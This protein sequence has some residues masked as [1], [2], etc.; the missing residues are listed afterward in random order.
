[1]RRRRPGHG[2]GDR[3][4]R[5]IPRRPQDGP[6]RPARAGP[7]ARRGQAAWPGGSMRTPVV[8]IAASVRNRANSRSA[9]SAPLGATHLD[10]GAQRRVLDADGPADVEQHVV[11][12]GQQRQPPDPGGLLRPAAQPVEPA[13]VGDEPFQWRPDRARRRTTSPRGGPARQP[14]QVHQQP[15]QHHGAE[16]DGQEDGDP[17]DDWVVPGHGTDATTPGSA[18]PPPTRRRRGH[19][20]CPRRARPEGAIPAAPGPHGP[21]R[22]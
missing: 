6:A 8:S 3:E 12:G 4:P 22:G 1:M 20:R 16:G 14:G 13:Q 10:V 19:R 2:A 21:G 5:L 15:H 11:V 7:S 17:G 18:R 9:S